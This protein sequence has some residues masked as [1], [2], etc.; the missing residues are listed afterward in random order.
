M[1]LVRA[2]NPKKTLLLAPSFTGYLHALSAFPNPEYF[3]LKKEKNFCLTKEDFSELKNRIKGS[4]V[5]FLIITNPNN[6]DGMLFDRNLLDELVLFCREN[7]VFILIDETFKTLT[8]SPEITF[9]PSFTNLIIVRAFTK[10]F[11]LAGLRLGWAFAS[12]SLIARIKI[13]LPEWNLSLPAQ[14]TGFAIL[15]Q[16]KK[17]RRYLKKSRNLIKKE[18]LYLS[19]KLKNLGFTVYPS[20]AAFILFYSDRP[21]VRESLFEKLYKK[22]KIL[23]RDCSDYEGLEKGFFRIGI[24]NHRE[25]KKLIKKIQAEVLNGN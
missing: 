6:P 15:S 23:I 10:T 3:Y 18:R 8:E 12:S 14:E 24:K 16:E 1:S 2:L 22:H 21:E 17:I 25:N 5:D 4:A 7:R 13:Q 20:D 19:E 11:A 9:N